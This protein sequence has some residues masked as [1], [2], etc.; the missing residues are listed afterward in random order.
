MHPLWTLGILALF[1]VP[2][3]G[4]GNSSPAQPK[5]VRAL[6]T[7]SMPQ[8]IVAVPTDPAY[9][10][11]VTVPLVVR[12]SAGVTAYIYML[13]VRTTDEA[14]GAIS[15]PQ[16]VRAVERSGINMDVSERTTFE[17]GEFRILPPQ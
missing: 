7:F 8:R 11:E 15:Y 3:V 14:T 4:C 6:V 12:E 13:S 10:M 5:I 1:A 16:V 17:S 9:A 2:A